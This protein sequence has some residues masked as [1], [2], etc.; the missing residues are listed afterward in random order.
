MGI[1]LLGPIKVLLNIKARA[2]KALA[3]VADSLNFHA[4][5]KV[6]PHHDKGIIS[7]IGVVAPYVC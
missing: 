1:L 7:L 5:I 4:T 2:Q 3:S 6:L